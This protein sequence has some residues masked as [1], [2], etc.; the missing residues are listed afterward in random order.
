MQARKPLI[1]GN[2]KMNKT[3][4]QAKAF[5]A[6]F[7]ADWREIPDREIALMVPFTLLETVQTSI[8][9][10]AIGLGAQNIFWEKSGAFTGE[11]SAEMLKDAGCQYTLV[12]HSERRTIFQ[13]TDQ[14]VYLKIQSAMAS[15]II[16][17]C[18]V[19]EN[20]QQREAGEAKIVV[21]RQLAAA[22]QKI[23][24]TLPLVVAYE[25]VWAIGTGKVASAEDAQDMAQFIRETLMRFNPAGA[26]IRI[27]YGGSVSEQSIDTL[28]QQPD[29]DGALVGG[30]SLQPDAFL[31][32]AR[33]K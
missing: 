22:L 27:L 4:T 32:I 31:K 9:S 16:P 1:A 12:G 20:L 8:G 30:A 25:P 13:E 29:I 3:R 21:E 15:G 7:L 17:I 10:A 2:W 18:C 24:L 23:D 28:M 11:I 19:G 6:E 5:V 14:D 26:D 33:F